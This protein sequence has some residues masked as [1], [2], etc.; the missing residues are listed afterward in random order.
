MRSRLA[1]LPIFDVRLE[2]VVVLA[3]LL[4]IAAAA[5]WPNLWLIPTFTDETIEVK[6]AYDIARGQA[7]PLTNVDPYIGA[8]WNWL[9]AIGFWIFGLNP[10]LPRFMAFLGGV[11]TVGAAWWLGREVGGRAGGRLGAFVT[12]LFMAGC[13]THVLVNSHVAWSHATTP[14]WTTLGFAC[15]IRALRSLTPNPTPSQGSGEEQHVSPSPRWR[16]GWGAV[17]IQGSHGTEGRESSE[18]PGRLE[19]SGGSWLI[20]AGFFLGLGVQ[21][22][23]TAVLL[24]PGAALALLLQRPGLLR[25]RWVVFGALAFAVATANLLIY[26]VQTAGGSLRGGQAVLTDYTGQDE[27]VDAGNYGENIS[28]LTLATAWVLSGAIEKR[29]FVGETLAQ[30]LLI[31]YLVLAVGSILWAARRG[32][33]LPLLVAVPYVLALPLLQGKYEPILNGRYVM[34]ILPLVFASIGLVVADILAM[35]RRR[36]PARAALF[37][38]ALLGLTALAAL[39]P[40]APLA[41]YQ[42]SARTNHAILAAHEAVLANRSAG[43]V[44]VIDFGLDSVFFMAAGSA[45]KST[46]L[47]LGGSAVPYTV[48]DARQSSVEDALSGHESRLLILNTEKVRSLGRNFTLVPLMGG[49]RDGPGF[50]VFRVTARP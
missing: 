47:L 2:S 7:A 19:R 28:R 5:R 45:Y 9:L 46:E 12:A 10:W 3:G 4:G 22:H 21:T 11:A 24:L 27:G 13:S 8:L 25:T 40:L 33:L 49:E 48:I 34:P 30:P 17:G 1:R 44:V 32:R 35:Q 50:G 23:I 20:G 43:E 15:L 16:G 38:G 29:R 36:W 41:A 39:Y 37:G 6:L 31:G 14:L 18:L 42:R 26:N